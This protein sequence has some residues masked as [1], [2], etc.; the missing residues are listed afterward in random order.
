MPHKDP[1]VRRAFL[2]SFNRERMARIR[3]EWLTKHGPCAECGSPDNLELHYV[4]MGK[5]NHRVFSYTPSRRDALLKD[6]QVLCHRCRDDRTSVPV[7]TRA[8]ILH[9]L[10]AGY[11]A[12][13]AAQIAGVDRS[14]VTR[15]WKSMDGASLKCGCG[16]DAKH[17]GPCWWRLPLK[18]LSIPRIED[19]RNMR[20]A[21]FT[22]RQIREY[23]RR[24]AQ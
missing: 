16:R 4:G 11:G 1:V 5:A 6:Y 21:R 12:R 3:R 15:Y 13:S 14:T 8:E 7:E 9:L 20:K 23:L 22:I 18:Q 10:M 19:L 17:T 24:K 2:R